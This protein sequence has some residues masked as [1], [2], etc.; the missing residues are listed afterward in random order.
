MPQHLRVL[1]SPFFI[2]LL[3]VIGSVYVS[4]LPEIWLAV[5]P[6]APYFLSITAL[7]MAWH[8]NKGRVFVA[9]LIVMAALWVPS[10]L[11]Q[12]HNLPLVPT[13]LALTWL[14]L[15]RERGCLNRFTFNR[16]FLFAV[17]FAWWGALQTGWVKLPTTVPLMGGEA[18]DGRTEFIESVL[19]LGLIGLSI[20]LLL[21]LW[22]RRVDHFSAC[23]LGTVVGII[24]INV[25]PITRLHETILFSA[26]LF[27]WV[28]QLLLESRH[29][30]YRDEL[31][32]LPSRR[33]LNDAMAALPSNYAIA[34]V[35][36]DHFKQFN[37]TYGHDMGDVV[38]QMVAKTLER[39]RGPA[40]AFRYGGEEFT[41]VFRGKHVEGAPDQL[42]WV[43]EEI[44]EVPIDVTTARGQE[45][46]IN[47]TV[48]I[49]WAV[50][51]AGDDPSQVIKRADE[52]LYKAKKKG[53]NCVVGRA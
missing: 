48:S 6:W 3:F 35:D 53:R 11:K 38:L 10:Y 42:N 20:T 51:E 19:S 47:V 34:M 16:I 29:M 9:V 41:L 40:Q 26:L 23:I 5:L 7:F 43:R 28:W 22:W 4:T 33:A 39:Y 49:G 30:A 21:A 27:L 37:D 31:T 46:V 1:L 52:A 17:L 13:V 44:E 8:F 50:P 2:L 24:L 14:S 12:D 36:V 18:L 32:G 25:L 15:M 45:K